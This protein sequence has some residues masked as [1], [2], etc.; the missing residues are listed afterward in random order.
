[1]LFKFYSL[2]SAHL[3]EDP[4]VDVRSSIGHWTI[5]LLCP[6]HFFDASN[7]SFPMAKISAHEKHILSHVLGRLTKL[8]AEM[9]LI[10]QALQRIGQRWADFQSFFE[11]ILD[12]GDSLMRPAEH[13][14]LLFDDGAFSR[15]RRY[16]WAIDC[17]SEFENNITD[18]MTQW[19]LWKKAHVEQPL[20]ENLLTEIEVAQYKSAEQQY[21]VLGN[22]REY[23]RRKLAATVALRDAVS[24]FNALHLAWLQSTC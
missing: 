16:F 21:R 1:M 19:D 22:Q 13:D 12:S 18:N 15:S 17:L 20:N 3:S 2:S 7:T 11:Y 9:H 24:L 4:N 23:F 10:A 8:G 6:S 14:N 5:L